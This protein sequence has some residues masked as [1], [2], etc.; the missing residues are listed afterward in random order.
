[1]VFLAS[2]V[3]F[4]H[5]R[6]AVMDLYFCPLTFLWF[7]SQFAILLQMHFAPLVLSQDLSISDWFTCPSISRY[8]QHERII[9]I[10]SFTKI[11]TRGKK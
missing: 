11:D 3:L 1:M 5:F 2:F 4:W 7:Y 8:M 6:S 10:N 9:N